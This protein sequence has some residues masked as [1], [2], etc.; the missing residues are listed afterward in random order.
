[1]MWT[2]QFWTFRRAPRDDDSLAPHQ[3]SRLV[4][5]H[6]TLIVS[7]DASGINCFRSQ[8]LGERPDSHCRGT[9]LAFRPTARKGVG[10]CSPSKK[11]SKFP[12]A[13]GNPAAAFSNA[14][15]S[16]SGRSQGGNE[17]EC[18]HKTCPLGLNREVNV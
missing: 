9:G 3:R 10:F 2:S 15:L 11:P 12:R 8:I 16:S 17:L 13:P 4:L 6:L 14:S 1:M 18:D 7:A 5:T